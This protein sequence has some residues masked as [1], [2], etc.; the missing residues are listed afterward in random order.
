MESNRIGTNNKETED[1]RYKGKYPDLGKILRNYRENL[2]RI[3]PLVMAKLLVVSRTRVYRYEQGDIPRG[4]DKLLCIFE[5]YKIPHEVQNQFYTRIYPAAS[6]KTLPYQSQD[7]KNTKS[8]EKSIDNE[9]NEEE[10]WADYTIS[11]FFEKGEDFINFAITTRLDGRPDFSVKLLNFWIPFLEKRLNLRKDRGTNL[12]SLRK[13]YLDALDERFQANGEFLP[14]NILFKFISPDYKKAMYL[15]NELNDKIGEARTYFSLSGIYYILKKPEASISYGQ[16]SLL[17]LDQDN[18]LWENLRSMM[19]DNAYMLDKKEYY[20]NEKKALD[21][22]QKGLITNPFDQA[23]LFE[24]IARA[25][26]FLG[27]PDVRKFFDKA[28]EEIITAKKK[29]KKDEIRPKRII[30]NFRSKMVWFKECANHNQKFDRDYA[31]ETAKE[32]ILVAK[33]YNFERQLIDIRQSIEALKIERYL[34]EY[35]T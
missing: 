26:A 23:G 22:F 1:F 14:E 34:G 20:S 21:I 5:H 33:A 4:M 28:D 32:G 24:G 6:L 10:K 27:L 7:I 2:F 13:L 25:R 18:R 9:L 11:E 8:I 31:I 29:C 3:S 15:A 30:Q 19:I 12:H 16:K 35:L 17:A